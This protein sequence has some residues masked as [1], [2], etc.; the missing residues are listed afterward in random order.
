M[1]YRW[2]IKELTAREEQLSA[3]LSD[4]LGISKVAA[5]LF[6]NRG[7]TSAEAARSFIRPTKT[8][9]HDPFLMRDMEAAERRLDKAVRNKERILVYGDYDVD[10]T[11]AVSLVYRFLSFVENKENVQS[12]NVQSTK[13]QYLRFY[14]PDRYKEGYGISFQGI[15]YAEAEGCSLII[16]LDCGIK[17]VDKV[18]YARK[19]NIDFI[20]CDHHKPGDEL[21]K[22]VAVLN[23]HREDCPYPYKELSG[24]GVGFKLMQAYAI[25]HDISFSVLF[26]LL[27]LLGMSIASDIVPINGENRTLVSLGL[28]EINR[29]TMPGL[30]A[31]MRTAALEQGAIGITDLIFRFG[32]RVNACGRI[33]SGAEAVKLLI[34]DN[35]AE[36]E[37]LAQ[38]VEEHNTERKGLDK[39]IFEEAVSMLQADKENADKYST[40]V[41]SPKWHKGV[42]GIVAS[43]LVEQYYRPTVVFTQD[44]DTGMISGSARSVDDFDLYS[45][46][47]SCSDLL[48]HFGGHTFAAGLSMP[49]ENLPEFKQRFENYVAENILPSRRQPVIYIDAKITLAD[50]TPQFVK[51]LKCMEPFGPGNPRPIFLTENLINYRYTRRVGKEGEHLHLNVTD[52]STSP[53]GAELFIDGIAFRKGDLALHLQNGHPVDIC[54]TLEEN[55]FGGRTTIQMKAEDIIPSKSSRRDCAD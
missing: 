18:Q 52:R 26:N 22:A 8:P 40:V 31:L 54:Y 41:F 36:A 11:T 15:D 6:V 39:S 34:T 19:R 43:R 10:G 42:I 17:A 32:P 27:P 24:C 45:A 38:A 12:Y 47:E 48:T 33:R 29:T 53:E 21:P 25:R 37:E 20:I 4:E 2:Q 1:D 46:I 16:A 7:V 44:P 9:L 28:Q 23:P 3:L 49:L 30:V 35:M 14:I 13:E 50:I 51:I 55:H 5:S